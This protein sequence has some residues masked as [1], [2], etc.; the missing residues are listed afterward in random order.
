[1][2]V[3]AGILIVFLVFL[4]IFVISGVRIVRPYQRGIIEQLGKFKEVVDPPSS[5][6][7]RA[8]SVMNSSNSSI[9]AVWWRSL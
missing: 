9:A 2:S 4:F 8:G 3:G 6:S 7:S 1:M 5:I